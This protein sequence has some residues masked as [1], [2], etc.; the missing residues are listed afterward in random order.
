MLTDDKCSPEKLNFLKTT[1]IFD[2]LSEAQMNFLCSAL[3]E[4]S[5]TDGTIMQEN[6]IGDRIY[7]IYSGQ[8]EITKENPKLPQQQEFQIATLTKGEIFGD[9]ALLGKSKRSASAQAH[10]ET[11]LLALP[12]RFLQ[13]LRT[14]P[15]DQRKK[16]YYMV[17]ENLAKNL[18]YRMRTTNTEAITAINNKLMHE[19]ARVATGI[20]ITA[21]MSIIAL[22]TVTL[23]FLKTGQTFIGIGTPIFLIVS[24]ILV[25]IAIKKTRY[26]RTMF[27]LNLNNWRRNVIEAIL[28]TLPILAL[29]IF[30]KW[31][32][33]ISM[34]ESH[35]HLFEFFS[36]LPPHFSRTHG[37]LYICI[38]LLFI[39]LQEFIIRGVLQTCLEEL[40]SAKY[41][42]MWAILLSNLLFAA[43]HMHT[44][45]VLGLASFLAGLF[46]GW[47]YARQ[48]SLVG[49]I[50]SH[51][52]LGVW[53]IFVVNINP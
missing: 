12:I 35:R 28:F 40:L 6:T 13:N 31:M 26:P 49:V 3:E 2:N 27:G 52:I 23:S 15:D 11:Q 47:L 10:G 22:Y 37:I 53:A 14:D 9:M 38:Y 24:G 51:W 5:I 44:Y 50:I 45:A 39:P 7:I 46:W 34:G 30:V 18:A 16:T 42:T 19:K 48:R 29:V 25:F 41:K 32:Y 8:V 20:L 33:L 43:S 21:L 1:R 4:I 17:I 36:Q